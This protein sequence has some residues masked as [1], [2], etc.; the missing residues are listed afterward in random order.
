MKKLY[1]GAGVIAALIAVLFTAL[2]TI[3]HAAGLPPVYERPTVALPGKRALIITTSQSVLA[4]PE[5]TEGPET[6]V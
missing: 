6:R 3:L 4:A 2:P 1:V 5:E